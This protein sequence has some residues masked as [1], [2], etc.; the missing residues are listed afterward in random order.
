MPSF[1]LSSTL[2]ETDAEVLA[3]HCSDHRFQAGFYEFLNLKLNLDENYDLLVLPGGPQCLTLVE[4][5]PKFSWA[6]WKWFRFLVDAHDLKRLILIQHQDCGWYKELPLHLHSSPEPRQRQE[7][8]LRRARAALAKER[9]ELSVE[10]YYAGWDASR[11][12]HHRSGGRLMPT[13]AQIAWQG[14][15]ALL[16]G[17]L[18][19]LEREHSQRGDEPLFAGRAHLPHHCS[20]RLSLRP[21]DPGGIHLGAARGAGGNVRHRG[22][23]LCGEAGGPH[24]GATTEFVAVLAFIFGALTALGFLIP[25][26]T[27]AVVTTL[28][29]SIKAPLHHLAEKIREEEIYAIL[30]FGI[31]SVIVLPLLPNRAYGPFQVL[32]PR[33]IWWMVVLDFRRQHGRATC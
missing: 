10:L 28:L 19:G 8:D 26:A 25:A 21:A 23:R 20:E 22:R 24:K 6:G 7:E 9:P 32:N 17:L 4:Y 11:A 16:M 15:M 18:I 3:I 27:F 14:A 13:Y 1:Q 31:V 30:K 29:L 33:L 12:H 2:H 5:L